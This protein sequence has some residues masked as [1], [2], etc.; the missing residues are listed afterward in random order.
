MTQDV[1]TI[2][3]FNTK[4]EAILAKGYLEAQGIGAYVLADDDSEQSPYPF[5]NITGVKLYVTSKDVTKAKELLK[6]IK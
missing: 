6:K 5:N 4:H 2:K 1:I 3:S